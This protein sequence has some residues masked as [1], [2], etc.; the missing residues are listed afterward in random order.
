MWIKYESWKE[1]IVEIK[2]MTKEMIE[3]E[4]VCEVGS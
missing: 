3:E 2:W 1:I 4:G